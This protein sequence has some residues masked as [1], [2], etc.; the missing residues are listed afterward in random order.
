[1]ATSQMGILWPMPKKGQTRELS[2]L[3]RGVVSRSVRRVMG[4]QTATALGESSGVGRRSVDRLLN[5][6]VATTL[7]TLEAVA[8]ALGVPPHQL[9]IEPPAAKQ[10]SDKRAKLKQP[11]QK[12][13]GPQHHPTRRRGDATH[14]K[15][16]K[17]PRR[18]GSK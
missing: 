4:E 6:K 1:M 13:F 16:G 11:Y 14:H 3:L 17:L 15:N 18:G 7:D 5:E 12:I 9:L 2:T 8:N 10:E